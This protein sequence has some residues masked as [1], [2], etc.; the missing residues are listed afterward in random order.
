[1]LL[2]LLLMMMVGTYEGLGIGDR[3][4]GWES[5]DMLWLIPFGL[6]EQNSPIL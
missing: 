2:L 1:M 3:N 6:E 4:G 5:V